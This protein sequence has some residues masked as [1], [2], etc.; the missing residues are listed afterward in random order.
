[1]YISIFLGG[2]GGKGELRELTQ[3]SKAHARCTCLRFLLRAVRAGV[4]TNSW[5][6]TSCI[7][8]YGNIN[9]HNDQLTLLSGVF[10]VAQS[11][12]AETYQR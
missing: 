1:M 3:F 10:C 6:G 12:S 7:F 2:G 8:M 5:V 11:N 4:S 9:D